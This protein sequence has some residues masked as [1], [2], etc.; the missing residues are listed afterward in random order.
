MFN[1]KIAVPTYKRDTFH[2]FQS[3]GE[4]QVSAEVDVL[5]EGYQDLKLKLDELM[6]L[7]ETEN[8]IVL[9]LAGLHEKIVD[10]TKELKRLEGDITAARN[11]LQ[12]LEAFLQLLGIN[13]KS[14]YLDIDNKVLRPILEARSTDVKT[15]TEVEVDSTSFDEDSE[16]EDSEYEE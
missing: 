6:R 4:L 5:S 13:P 2:N 12:K 1:L 16:Y 10:K 15:E 11:Q 3:P 14:H 7:V 8:Q 9:D